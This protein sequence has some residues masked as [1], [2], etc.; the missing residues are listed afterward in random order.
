[1]R[2]A[3]TE[4]MDLWR[5]YLEH[6]IARAIADGALP[7]LDD[8]TQLGFELEALLSHA[9]AQSTLHDSSEP[10]RRA[11]RAI[12]ERLRALGGDPHVLEFVRAP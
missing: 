4:A 10:Y 8:A 5:S 7:R 11:E 1:M 2:D 9:N 12:V 3:I 6:Q